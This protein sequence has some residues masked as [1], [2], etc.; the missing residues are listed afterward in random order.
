M[1]RPGVR[2]K[3]APSLCFLAAALAAVAAACGGSSGGQTLT[4]AA[5]ADL[6]PA[7]IEVGQL[8]RQEAGVRVTFSF[9]SSGRLAAQI[10]QGAP[11]DVFASADIGIVRQLRQAG[12]LLADS[13]AVYALGRLALVASRDGIGSLEGL[14]RPQVRRIALANP[15]HAPYG[16]AAEEALRS[17]GLWDKVQGKVVFGENVRQAFQF[18]QTGQAEAGLV[19][20]SLAVADGVNYVVVDDSLH[21]PI[22][23]AAAVVKDTKREAPA[24]RFVAFLRAPKA[25]QVF[26][27]YGFLPPEE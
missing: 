17:A 2:G 8:F 15:A 7:L 19:A 18:V 5:A 4:V 26:A 9:G 22:I 1:R 25:Q 20:L 16:R 21:Q 10:E 6:Q 13:E 14:S 23:Q 3:A 12:H 11:Y 24:R 27:R